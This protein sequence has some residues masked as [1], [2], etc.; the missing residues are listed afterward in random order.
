MQN[1]RSTHYE[2]HFRF[3]IVGYECH[4]VYTET[5]STERYTFRLHENDENVH[6]NDENVHEN[7]ENVHENVEN[8]HKN[9]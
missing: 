3:V 1:A 4:P 2:A 9:T 5:F 6:E 8:V 7:D